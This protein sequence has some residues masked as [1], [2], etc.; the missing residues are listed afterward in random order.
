L[1]IFLEK[2][3]EGDINRG[4]VIATL[5]LSIGF[6]W[7]SDS[8]KKPGSAVDS[9]AIKIN[10]KV[11]PYAIWSTKN[12]FGSAKDFVQKHGFSTNQ[13][14]LVGVVSKVIDHTPGEALGG[15]KLAI[16]YIEDRK[17]SGWGTSG[18]ALAQF[19]NRSLKAAQFL[20]TQ[21]IELK[22][23]IFQTESTELEI[24]FYILIQQNDEVQ[25]YGRLKYR[26][27][28]GDVLK[29]LGRNPCLYGPSEC[30]QVQNVK[31]GVIGYVV[32]H[33]MREQHSIR[34]ELG[35]EK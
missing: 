15:T 23:P 7:L 4:L 1:H 25:E 3:D 20:G 9:G 29:V 33:R 18:S 13:D 22:T 2:G 12:F 14:L 10:G 26:V 34:K 24:P 6:H 35:N 30:W 31:T 11:W 21:S 16:Y 8:V 28:K 27:Q 17:I 19:K 32:A 5:K